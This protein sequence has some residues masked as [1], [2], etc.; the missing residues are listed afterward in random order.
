MVLPSRLP[1]NLT[2]IAVLDSRTSNVTSLMVE[3]NVDA[4]FKFND[5]NQP[6]NNYFCHIASLEVFRGWNQSIMISHD[7]FSL[8]VNGSIEVRQIMNMCC[9][10]QHCK[11]VSFSICYLETFQINK[12]KLAYSTEDFIG[13]LYRI[14]LSCS[15]E[16]LPANGCLFFKAS[17]ITFVDTG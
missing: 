9:V 8:T 7:G 5:S 16:G 6:V 3:L 4:M 12:N 10:E 15:G 14:N 13:E 17:G 1:T 11:L 2:A